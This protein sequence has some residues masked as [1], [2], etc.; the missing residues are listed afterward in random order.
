MKPV[1]HRALAQGPWVI[2]GAASGFGREFAQRLGAR[3]APLALWDRDETGLAR[4]ADALASSD[5]D[6]E[7]SRARC[8]RHVVDVC[9]P[10]SIARALDATRAQHGAPGHLIHCAG[11]LR[12][13]AL[14]HASD[15]D[16]RAM[17]DVNVLGTAFTV[18]ALLGSLRER[19]AQGP[20]P[21]TLTLFASVAGLR[22]FAEMSG[23]CA[24]KHAVL[25]LAQSLR[26]ELL[27]E[28]APIEVRALCPPPADTPMVRS[29]A[30]R[31]RVYK[32][33]RMFSASQVVEEALHAIDAPPPKGDFRV[34]VGLDQRLLF[35][36]ER[37]AP[38]L[39]DRGLRAAL[40]ALG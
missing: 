21:A 1:M 14:E 12:V 19:G 40:R 34:L 2:T 25:G 28:R 5:S 29:L 4:V 36:I 38:G 33:S 31:P 6:R 24:S 26:D 17:L 15:D 22:G 10:S 9:D 35:A 7:G 32:L 18:R 30:S 8:T 23:Y 11:I 3:G 27:L 39:F 16:L 13:G 37:W 20:G